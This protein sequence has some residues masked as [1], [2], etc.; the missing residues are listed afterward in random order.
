[1]IGNEKL[2][3]VITARGGSRRL[4]RKNVLTFAG[5]PLIAWTIEAGLQ[6]KYVDRVIV[7]TDDEEI[8]EISRSHGAEVPFMRPQELSND[9]ASSTDVI[10]HAVKALENNEQKFGYLLY[11]QPTSPLRTSDHIDEA[12]ALMIQKEA[13]GV[14][15]V[16]AMNHPIEWS[17]ILPEN[18][19]MDGFISKNNQE[20][21]S[22]DFPQ[23]YCV[24]GAIYLCKKKSVI[25]GD[26]SF[27]KEGSYAYKMDPVDSVDIDTQKDFLVAEAFLK[28]S[29][30]L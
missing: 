13:N 25:E 3:A 9:T 17:N 27:F 7:S 30:N 15:G 19:S 2:L 8:A 12:V 23:R 26:G 22:Q 10:R 16:T 29:R 11:L 28:Y 1:M 14:I 21:R 20:K 18:L 4:P 24:N 6:S 5:K